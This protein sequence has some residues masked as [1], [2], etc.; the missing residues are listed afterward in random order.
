M[1]I[2]DSLDVSGEM[3][4]CIEDCLECHAFCERTAAHCLQMEGEHASRE[5]QTALRDCAQICALSADFMIRE[6]PIHAH[7]C[8]A[9]AVA[10][11][12]CAGEC[13]RMAHGDAMMNFCSEV[14]RRCAAS[15]RHMASHGG[16]P[17][18]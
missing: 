9:C 10:C 16:A 5:H 1:A 6:S 8:A 4:R 3:R 13:E 15:C 18:V 2:S 17:T 14:C 12:R 7:T 11:E